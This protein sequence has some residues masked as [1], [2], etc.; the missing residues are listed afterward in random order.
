MIS[1]VTLEKNE[2]HQQFYKGHNSCI[3]LSLAMVKKANKYFNCSGGVIVSVLALFAV[4][5]VFEAR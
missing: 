5:R 1:R 2:A 4:D 3:L